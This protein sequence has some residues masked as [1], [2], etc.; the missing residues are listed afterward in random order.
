M[1][2]WGDPV[3]RVRGLDVYLAVRKSRIQAHRGVGVQTQ[4]NQLA[5]QSGGNYSVESR[6]KLNKQHGFS[7][8]SVRQKTLQSLISRWNLILALIASTSIYIYIQGIWQT[9][10]PKATYKEYIC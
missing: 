8:V 10:L 9:L 2:P 7:H 1:Q 5:S 3:F 4:L 6:T